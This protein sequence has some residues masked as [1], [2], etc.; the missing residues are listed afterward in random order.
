MAARTSSGVAG[1]GHSVL[2]P[3]AKGRVVFLGDWPEF[4]QETFDPAW[5]DRYYVGPPRGVNYN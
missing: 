4:R 5:Q 1:E 2:C 3:Y